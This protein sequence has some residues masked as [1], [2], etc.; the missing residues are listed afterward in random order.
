MPPLPDWNFCYC[1]PSVPFLP[2]TK[3][4]WIK[5]RISVLRKSIQSHIDLRKN[6][7]N[8]ILSEFLELTKG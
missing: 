3:E 6:V 4:E 2:T 5:E 7:P 8:V 1:V